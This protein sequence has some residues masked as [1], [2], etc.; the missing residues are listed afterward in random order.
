MTSEASSR[1]N[2]WARG[3]CPSTPPA[4]RASTRNARPCRPTCPRALAHPTGSGSDSRP[5]GPDQFT[6]L[7]GPDRLVE[8]ALGGLVPTGRLRRVAAEVGEQV[9]GLDQLTSQASPGT[10]PLLFV[11]VGSLLADLTT[12]C[13]TAAS[14]AAPASSQLVCQISRPYP[15]ISRRSRGRPFRN[16]V[17]S[18]ASTRPP[19]RPASISQ[20]CN[21]STDPRPI[22]IQSGQRPVF[23]GPE[24]QLNTRRPQLKVV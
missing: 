15:P 17:R 18:S 22:S 20:P 5:I 4:R 21:I 14:P 16:A 2:L 8:P 19:W 7:S 9:V 6:H 24:T 23:D 12:I 3:S 11:G 13:I 1:F 10:E